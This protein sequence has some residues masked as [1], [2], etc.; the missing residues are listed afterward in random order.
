M[1]KSI[2]VHLF[3]EDW[4]RQSQRKAQMLAH[5]LQKGKTA[6]EAAHTPEIFREPLQHPLQMTV[7][8]I[9][10]SQGHCKWHGTQWNEGGLNRP[11]CFKYQ[12]SWYKPRK[13]FFPC[14]N[15]LIRI[16][17]LWWDK[18]WAKTFSHCRFFFLK[19]TSCW[20]CRTNITQTLR[21]LETTTLKLLEEPEDGRTLLKRKFIQEVQIYKWHL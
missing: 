19:Q 3:P 11:G 21:Q 6:E 16:K 1:V 5:I 12:D 2:S 18:G 9:N 20:V 13:F 10:I 15:E 14:L 17:Q 8:N 7:K 4:H